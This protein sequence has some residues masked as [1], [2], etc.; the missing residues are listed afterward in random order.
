L[1]DLLDVLK[2]QK[3]WTPASKAAEGLGLG[4]GASSDD[5]E[6]FYH[7]LKQYVESSAIEIERRG[8][9]DWLRLAEVEAN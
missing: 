9:E 4:D 1:T 7:Q 8:D 6:A 5:I 2:Q 3:S